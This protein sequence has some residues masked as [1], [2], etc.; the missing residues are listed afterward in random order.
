MNG[1]GY[2]PVYSSSSQSK[3]CI[4]GFYGTTALFF[5]KADSVFR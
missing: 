5:R 2:T 4:L 1:L 3:T